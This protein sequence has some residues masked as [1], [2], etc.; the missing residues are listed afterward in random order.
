[1]AEKFDFLYVKTVI[2]VV[3]LLTIVT[4]ETCLADCYAGK[5]LQIGDRA[6]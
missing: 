4:I 1:M 3:I 5:S 2:Q 6:P